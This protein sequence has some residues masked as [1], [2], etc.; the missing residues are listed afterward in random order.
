[1]QRMYKIRS[2]Q[3]WNEKCQTLTYLLILSLFQ[4][5]IQVYFL[6][7]FFI[8]SN[9]WII[10][11]II[12]SY[13]FNI[14]SL[15]CCWKCWCVHLYFQK[16]SSGLDWTLQRAVFGPQTLCLTPSEIIDLWHL[17]QS[18]TSSNF[19]LNSINWLTQPWAGTEALTHDQVY[20][21]IVKTFLHWSFSSSKSTSE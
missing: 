21:G 8:S 13:I 5:F 16:L 20:S 11:I 7:L 12:Y 17:Q 2:I 19:K 3:L 4:S 14:Y 1:M 6:L 18:L 15:C 9:C 10:F